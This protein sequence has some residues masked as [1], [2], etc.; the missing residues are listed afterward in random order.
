MIHSIYRDARGVTSADDGGT[1][2]EVDDDLFISQRL[3]SDGQRDLCAVFHID[4][5]QELAT[6]HDT[7]DRQSE[8]S[9]LRCQRRQWRKIDLKDPISS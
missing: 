5:G 2:S 4:S 1:T 3:V 7:C 9:R 8:Q 6:R